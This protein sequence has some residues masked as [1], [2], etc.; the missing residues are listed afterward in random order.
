MGYG[1]HQIQ[2]L[3]MGWSY[4]DEMANYLILG[5]K[6]PKAGGWTTAVKPLPS[7]DP[8]NSCC[9]SPSCTLQP[10]VSANAK[11]CGF[12]E[13]II[14]T[15]VAFCNSESRRPG[16]DWESV[17]GQQPSQSVCQSPTKPGD[18]DPPIPST[19]PNVALGP[20]LYPQHLPSMW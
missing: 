8:T 10:R 19:V 15:F 13:P 20:P 2:D 14:P 17:E 7:A 5:C 12:G 11:K 6:S 1:W 16:E 3:P 9:P 4:D 18:K